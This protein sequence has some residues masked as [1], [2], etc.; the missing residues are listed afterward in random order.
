LDA[1]VQLVGVYLTVSP[2]LPALAAKKEGILTLAPG[3][4]VVRVVGCDVGYVV[5]AS[6]SAVSSI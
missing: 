5:G 6:V 2:A 4:V 3:F 1:I